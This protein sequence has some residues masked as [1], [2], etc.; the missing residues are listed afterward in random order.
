MSVDARQKATRKLTGAATLVAA[1]S[2]AILA[3]G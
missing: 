3:V 1:A 2:E